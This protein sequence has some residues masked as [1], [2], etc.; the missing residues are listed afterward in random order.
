[1][2][3]E[4]IIAKIDKNSYLSNKENDYLFQL[5]DTM[6]SVEQKQI[7]KDILFR[8]N[9]GIVFHELRY[10][11]K[12]SEYDDLR[13]EAFIALLKAIENYD[14]KT[15]KSFYSYAKKCIL[16]TIIQYLNYKKRLIAIPRDFFRKHPDIT[17]RE[18]LIKMFEPLSL[19]Q[20]IDETKNDCDELQTALRSETD[21]EREVLKHSIK[22]LI[23]E[24]LNHLSETEQYVLIHRFGLYDHPILTLQEIADT[25]NSTIGKINYIET[26]AI[27]KLANLSEIKNLK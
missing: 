7:I 8:G 21:I 14:Y 1:M 2:S 13:Q 18:E 20:I 15:M 12:D 17:E 9:T 23:I 4:E 22:E 5:I 27:K 16:Y 19:N 26:S 24:S 6:N 10:Y 25:L 11:K 3:L